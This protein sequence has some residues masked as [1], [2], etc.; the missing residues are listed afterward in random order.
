MTRFLKILEDQG[1]FSEEKNDLNTSGSKPG[2][3][4]GFP[5]S[6]KN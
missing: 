1:E 6:I 5:K 3:Y 2:F 4:M